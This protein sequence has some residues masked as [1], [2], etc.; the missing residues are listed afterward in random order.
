MV[1]TRRSLLGAAA[2]LALA[3]IAPAR[4]DGSVSLRGRAFGTSWQVTLGANADAGTLSD[5]IARV[6]ADVDAAM[7]PFRRDSEL[8]RFNAFR[9]TEPF[10]ASDAFLAVAA[11]ARRIALCTSGAF[12]PCVGPLVHRFGFG[13][14]EGAHLA[15]YRDFQIGEGGLRKSDPALSLDLCGIA[16]GYAVDRVAT[17]LEQSGHDDFLVEIGGE[18]RARGTAAGGRPWRV[19]IADPLSGGVRRV[20]RLDGAAIATSGD[21]LHF[22]EIA[23]RRYSHVMD[24]PRREP[25]RNGVA[26]VSVMHEEAAVA[27]AFATALMVAGPERGLEL[28]REEGFGALYLLRDG[29]GGLREVANELFRARILA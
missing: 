15:S 6:L 16:K 24:P 3:G 22:Y 5:G 8:S 25:V 28:A 19:G 4:A 26:S 2:G 9:G 20:V 10:A 27:D 1:L 21:A 17:H 13:P 29:S 18:F 11:A 12:D 23:G 14:I 7:S